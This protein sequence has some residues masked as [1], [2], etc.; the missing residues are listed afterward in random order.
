MTILLK[1]HYLIE[2]KSGYFFKYTVKDELYHYL[3]AI[4]KYL[5]G[6]YFGFKKKFNK[7]F[8]E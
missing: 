6:I 1:I 7:I 3:A 5:F 4:I 2:S 8:R